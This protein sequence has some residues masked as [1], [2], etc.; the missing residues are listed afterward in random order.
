MKTLASFSN[1]HLSETILVCG[2]GQSLNELKQPERFITIG[3]NDIGRRFHPDY[4]VVVNPRDQFSGDRFH[5]VETSAARFLFTQLDL[6]LSRDNVVK[7]D[8]G[9]E[10]G[11]DWSDPHVLHYTQNS[12]YVAMCLALHMGAKRIGLIGVDFTDHHFFAPTGTHSLAPQF[13]LI[14]QQYARLYEAIKGRGLEVFNLSSTSRL[15]AFPKISLEEFAALAHPESNADLQ[16]VSYATTPVAGVPA[17]LARCINARTKHRAR[18]VWGTRSYGNGVDFTGDIEWTAAAGE[19]EAALQAADVVIVHNGKVEPQH[20]AILAGKAIVTMAHNYGWNV[21]ES[22]VRQGFP[23]VVVG[24]YQA[25][26]PEFEGWDVVPNPLPIWEDAFMPGT[27]GEAITVCFTPSGRH[28]RYALDHKLYWHSKGYETTMRA[29]ERLAA[30]YPIRLEVINGNQI[31]HD[32]SLAMKRRSHIVID[33]CVTGSYHRNSLEGLATGCVVVNGVGLLPGVE[34]VFRRCAGGAVNPFVHAGLDQLETVLTT[35][36]ERGAEMLVL[37]GINNRRWMESHWDFTQQWEQ[38]WAPVLERSLAGT[39]RKRVKAFAQAGE[40]TERSNVN[41]RSMNSLTT[42]EGVSVVIPHGGRERLP[43]L[44]ATLVNLQQCQGFNEIIVVDMGQAPYAQGIARRLADKYVFVHHTD[45]FQRARALNI[46]TAFAEFDL[47]LWNDNDLILP[48]GFIENAATELRARQLDNLIPYTDIRY[49]SEADSREVMAGTRNPVDCTAVKSFKA[50]YDASGGCGL[51]RKSFVVKYGGLHEGFRGWGGDDNAWSFKAQLLGSSSATQSSDRHVYHL[52]HPNSGGYGGNSHIVQNPHYNANVVLMNQIIT[53]RNRDE[54]IKRFP[55]AVHFSCPWEKEK[56]ITFIAD[57]SSAAL[58]QRIARALEDLYGV[59]IDIVSDP[60]WLDSLLGKTPDALVIFDLVPAKELLTDQRLAHLWSRLV[61]AQQQ[62]GALEADELNR[63]G[64]ILTSS[65]EPSLMQAEKVWMWKRVAESDADKLSDALSLAQPLSLV[66]G[67]SGR[68]RKT[69]DEKSSLHTDGAGKQIALPVWIYWEGECPAWIKECQQT[70]FAHAADVR[71]VTPDEFEK[72][73]DIDTDIDLKRLSPP[74]RADFIRAFLLG[75]F[76]GLWVDSDCL[77]MQPLQPLLNFL[78]KNDFLF[79]RERSGLV[80][81]GF[82]GACAN[83]RIAATLYSRLCEILRSGRPLGWCSLGSEPLTE[84]IRTSNEQRYELQ[85]ELIQPVCWSRPE[86]FFQIDHPADH[87]RNFDEQAICYMLSNNSI[88]QFTAAN[89]GRNLLDEGT[90][91]RY[92]LKKALD[93]SDQAVEIGNTNGAGSWQQ[94]PFYIKAM[95]DVAPHKILDVGIGFGRWG[96][97]IRE[98]CA[99]GN[100]GAAPVHVIGIESQRTEVV[101]HAGLFYDQIHLGKP[102]EVLTGND[103]QWDLVIFNEVTEEALGKALNVSDYVLVSSSALNGSRTANNGHRRNGHKFSATVTDLISANL[104]RNSLRDVSRSEGAL[105]LSRSDPKR[106]RRAN[107]TQRVFERIVESNLKVG[108]ES[109]SGPGSC[110]AQTAEIRQRL[111]FLIAGLNI[112]SMLDAPCGDFNWLK[113]VRL[114]LEEYIGG[115]IVP[116]L[117]E[118]NQRNFGNSQ[119]RFLHLDITSDYLPQVDLIFCRDCLVHFPF[120]EIA[121]ALKNFKRSR[122]KYLLTTTFT[123]PRP[124]LDI[125]MGEWR[126]LNLQMAPF[127]FPPP[128]RLIN[129]KCT[130]NNGTYADKCLGLWRL[131]DLRV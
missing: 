90:F 86:V 91:F 123:N 65:L 92:L 67:S 121:D 55:P 46:G 96:M 122:S 126:T 131:E 76:G 16:I 30:K 17:I 117:V 28:E 84:I 5:Y 6:G 20:R 34:D 82:I 35:L 4:L 77:V 113:H 103:E 128:L 116:T 41:R 62:S 102:L 54:F 12:P 98:F 127:N 112:K 71:L 33:E 100:N 43:H 11:T 15:T 120:S 95:L 38:F 119:R 129:E 69:S 44:T 10:G 52:F 74:Q 60:H 1:V 57:D 63:A 114:D 36:I 125:P 25:T 101:E 31:S 23:A 87:E 22:F 37:D 115:D 97:L 78:S 8:L 9:K 70:I 29:L 61:L 53:T 79:H 75:R 3:V 56:Q 40:R 106:L 13:Q 14:D 85:C 104:V 51:V 110:L 93:P 48:S 27:K 80:S 59:K 32:E 39:A 89:P 108:D 66:L 21:D 18:C 49:L 94:I 107:P 47:L 105:L 50:R 99:Q 109:I 7:F 24:Q 88:K 73:R 83:S 42:K 58:A 111:P 2:C 19:A 64:A 72:L 118:Q 124:N 68:R 81:N 26:L 130:E 45:A